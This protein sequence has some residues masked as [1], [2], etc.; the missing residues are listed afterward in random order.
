MI[1]IPGETVP[2][3]SGCPDNTRR[4]PM[5][6]DVRTYVCRPGTIK[7]HLALY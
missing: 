7:A 2:W 4:N 3:L 1:R 5:L 6:Y